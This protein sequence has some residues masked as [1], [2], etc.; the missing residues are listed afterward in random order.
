MKNFFWNYKSSF[1]GVPFIWVGAEAVAV[2]GLVFGL[3][4]FLI[5]KTLFNT[6]KIYYDMYDQDICEA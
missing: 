5:N 1:V 4:Y 2:S 6:T 3:G